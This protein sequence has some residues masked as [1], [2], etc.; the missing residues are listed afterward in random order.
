MANMDLAGLH[1]K[2]PKNRAL[3]NND[4]L[5]TLLLVCKSYLYKALNN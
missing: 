4:D 3:I 5:A 1:A 2:L